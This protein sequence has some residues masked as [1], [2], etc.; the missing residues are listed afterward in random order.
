MSMPLPQLTALQRRV[1]SRYV[2]FEHS[3]PTVGGMFAMSVMAYV[4]VIL[5]FAVCGA[6]CAAMNVYAAV[7]VLL[8]MFVGMISRDFGQYRAFVAIWPLLAA[9]IDWQR[10]NELLDADDELD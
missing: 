3:P 2:D 4:R 5:I 6:I 7:F 9:I 10:A 8:G 1:L